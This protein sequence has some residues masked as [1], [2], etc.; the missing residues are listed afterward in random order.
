[1]EVKIV[2][3]DGRDRD[4]CSIK[5]VCI[6][7]HVNSINTFDPA[8]FTST[9][10]KDCWGNLLNSTATAKVD[11]HRLSTGAR[12]DTNKFVFNERQMAH[13]S[14]TD[15]NGMHKWTAPRGSY[16]L[17]M[18]PSI[19]WYFDFGQSNTHFVFHRV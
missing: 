16:R 19:Q 7:F 13:P 18:I 10:N 3:E 4:G 2:S 17:F 1:M 8:L 15:S 5:N 9:K 6:R 12:V 14:I 11:I